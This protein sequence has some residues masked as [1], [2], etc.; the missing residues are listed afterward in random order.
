[1]YKRVLPVAGILAGLSIALAGSAVAGGGGG[2]GGYGGPGHSQ[3]SDTTAFATFGD[4]YSGSYSAL[5]YVDRGQLSFKTKHT[6]GAPVVEKFGTLLS[7][8]EFSGTTYEYGC[9]VI[10]DSAFTVA[11]DLSRASVN[12]H[13]T[14]D[15]QCP[16]YFV[17]S[18]T[19]GKPGLQSSIGYGG[20]GGG[21]PPTVITD[22]LVNL[23]WTGN[24]GLWSNSNSGTSHCGSYTANFHGTF[25]YQ[26]ASASGSVGDLT[27]QTDPLAQVGRNTQDI[28]A[29]STPSGACN[30]YGF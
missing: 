28:N 29:N 9:W 27:G 15:M 30:P 19:G 2:G 8:N 1:M 26:F 18:A 23:T 10:P 6:P 3:F 13:A 24:G 7:V 25:D 12:V 5:V 14:A 22:T 11:S 17:G 4:P 20:G 21:E 16:G